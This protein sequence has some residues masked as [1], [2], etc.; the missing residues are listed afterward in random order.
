MDTEKLRFVLTLLSADEATLRRSRN[1][2]LKWLRHLEAP[3]KSTSD[4]NHL[5]GELMSELSATKRLPKPELNGLIEDQIAR[6]QGSQAGV[7]TIYEH[8]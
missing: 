6:I 1:E 2:A 4:W 8:T 3:A 7:V 5:L